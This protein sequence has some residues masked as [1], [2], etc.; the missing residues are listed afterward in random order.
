VSAFVMAVDAAGAAGISAGTAALVA[1]FTLWIATLRAQRERRRELYAQAFAAVVAYR[2]F[3]YVIRRRRHEEA[4]RSEE[5]V[6]I[7]ESLRDVQRD[8]AFYEAM[9]ENE[10]SQKAAEAYTA[11]VAETRRVA[12]GYMQEEWQREPITIDPEMHM[13]NAFDYSCIKDTDAAYLAAAKKAVAWRR[14]W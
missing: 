1:L 2:E 3:P 9:L 11:V 12:G 5:R 7:S 6:R 14:V 13:G 10:P 4:H 8:L